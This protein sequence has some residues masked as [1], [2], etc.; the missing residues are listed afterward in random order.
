MAEGGPRNGPEAEAG[1]RSG[2]VKGQDLIPWGDSEMEDHPDQM[3]VQI[4]G[5]HEENE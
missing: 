1:R 5:G 3:S 4:K 2:K